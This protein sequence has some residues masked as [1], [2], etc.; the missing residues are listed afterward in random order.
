MANTAKATAQEIRKIF[1]L[2][3]VS[4]T[5]IIPAEMARK[6]ELHRGNHVVVEDTKDGI[7]VRKLRVESN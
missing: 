5:L 7:L 4:A 1:F 6:H 3:D 2:N